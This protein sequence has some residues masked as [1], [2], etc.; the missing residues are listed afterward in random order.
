[1][2]STSFIVFFSNN[3]FLKLLKFVIVNFG[4][5]STVLTYLT[6][7]WAQQCFNMYN[8][9]YFLALAKSL[10]QNPHESIPN[11]LLKIIHSPRMLSISSWLEFTKS[12]QNQSQHSKSKWNPIKSNQ[13]ESI[14]TF[15]LI[16]KSKCSSCFSFGTAPMPQ[17]GKKYFLNRW[18]FT[19]FSLFIEFVIE[20]PS[21]RSR[22]ILEWLWDKSWNTNYHER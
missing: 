11:S 10:M 9:N 15:Y 6:L 1:M 19:L 12:T 4:I 5:K 8:W 21:T 13:N 20:H 16:T 17:R 7:I 22:T 2:H 18:S 3:T 14:P